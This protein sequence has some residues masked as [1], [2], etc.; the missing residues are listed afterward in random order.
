M[1]VFVSAFRM[2]T[3]SLA[4]SVLD[5]AVPRCAVQEAGVRGGGAC[6]AGSMRSRQRTR[7]K[8]MWRYG[9]KPHPGIPCRGLE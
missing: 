2:E 3:A 9:A 6:G 4:Y 8:W 5:G 1:W 7:A